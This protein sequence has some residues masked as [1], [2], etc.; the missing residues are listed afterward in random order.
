MSK[1][2]LIISETADKQLENYKMT[3]NLVSYNKIKK[4]LIE[5]TQ[6]PYRGTGKPEALKYNLQ[7]LW[8]RRINQEDRMIN[9]VE[10]E[11]ERF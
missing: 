7:G 6:N 3:G 5:I 9:K 11:F 10:E 1:Y 8:S 4:I 2:K